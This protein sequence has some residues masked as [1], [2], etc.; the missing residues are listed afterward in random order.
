M[1]PAGDGRKALGSRG[2][3]YACR[4]LLGQGYAIVQR[5]FRCRMGEIDIIASKNN[6][7][8]FIEV[9]TRAS[10]RYGRPVEAVTKAKQ[11]KIYRCAEYYLQT[12]GISQSMPVL[13]FDVIEIITES[14]RVKEF[15]HYPHCF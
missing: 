13:S 9:K 8:C 11:Q 6:I 3:D 5:N 1:S 10:V 14:G 12:Q 2:E 15:R 4:Y 7:L